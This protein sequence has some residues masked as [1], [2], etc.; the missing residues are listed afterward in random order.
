[1]FFHQV[2]SA[3]ATL[4]IQDLDTPDT[5]D[6]VLTDIQVTHI[7]VRDLINSDFQNLIKTLIIIMFLS[8]GYAGYGGL[9]YY[10]K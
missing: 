1:M 6:L 2:D 8:K 9:S 7:P 4:D 5:P 10:K 3:T